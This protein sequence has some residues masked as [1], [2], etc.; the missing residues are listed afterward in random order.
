MCAFAGADFAML[1]V[2]SE[3]LQLT[4][5]QR[6]REPL[7]GKLLRFRPGVRG[8]PPALFGGAQVER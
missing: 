2:T 3:S 4:P 6:A 7:A 1:Y 8:R 5:E